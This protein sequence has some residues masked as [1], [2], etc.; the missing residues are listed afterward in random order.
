MADKDD[1]ISTNQRGHNVLVKT[2]SAKLAA[3]ATNESTQQPVK[4]NPR[5]R[6]RRSSAERRRTSLSRSSVDSIDEFIGEF[7]DR[8]RRMSSHL[9]HRRSSAVTPQPRMGSILGHDE[10]RGVDFEEPIE[11]DP[12]FPGSPFMASLAD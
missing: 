1:S 12:T 10:I 7:L 9:M 6:R 3:I 2:L 5:H 4:S 11:N 8:T